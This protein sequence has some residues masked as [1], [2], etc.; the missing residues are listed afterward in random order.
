MQ[1]YL[2]DT[3]TGERRLV[4]RDADGNL[5][6]GHPAMP[7]LTAD[8]ARLLFVSPATK[9]VSADLGAEVDA[10]VDTIATGERAR[11]R[12]VNLATG[13][14]VRPPC[15]ISPEGRWAF[16]TFQEVTQ[17]VSRLAD[18][19]GGS[20]APPFPGVAAGQPSFSR[21]G[22]K[23]A[24]SLSTSV[25]SG[26]NPHIEVH[27]TAAWF[28]GGGQPVTALWTSASP[29]TEPVLSGDGTRVAYLH[30]SARGTNAVVV[31]DWARNEVLFAHRLNR[32]FP[33]NLGLSANGRR[34]VWASPGT[35]PGSPTQAWCAEVETGEVQL[36][37]VAQDGISPGNGNSKF[38][39]ISADGRYVAFASRADNLVP[40]DGNGAK[41]VFLHD[42]QAGRTLLLSRSG[43]GRAGAGWSLRPFFSAD[44]RHVFFLSHAP[45]L[46]SGDFNQ[47]V[48]LFQVEILSET[49]PLLVI[50]RELTT[51]RA[52]L[53]WSGSSEQRY[54]IEYTDELGGEWTVLP[55]EFTGNATVDLESAGLARRFFRM[56]QL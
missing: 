41:D 50:Q 51:G 8:G 11:L 14:H 25:L 55:G 54:V 19:A 4:S 26:A 17:P 34:V 13:T 15:L 40:D 35:E 29:A 27:E 23:V 52:T 48:D 42:L 24:V 32:Q 47:S 49:G 12:P 36:V 43:S 46:V 37:S 9:L 53:L 30:I 5:A 1:V 3:R 56:R 44:G 18:V 31:T 28:T 39:A 2:H 38:T 16:L 20:F 7:S 10:F 22:Q 45:D 33:A 21:D 6:N